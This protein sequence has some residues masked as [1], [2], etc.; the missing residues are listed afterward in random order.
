MKTP[1]GMYEIV[2]RSIGEPTITR[3]KEGNE[4]YGYMFTLNDFKMIF[5]EEGFNIANKSWKEYIETWTVAKYLIKAPD[6]DVYFLTEK[7]LSTVRGGTSR[8]RELRH[9]AFQN[10]AMVVS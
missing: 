9:I 5:A 7:G 8:L 4:V 10:D 2:V 3:S 1:K 6:A